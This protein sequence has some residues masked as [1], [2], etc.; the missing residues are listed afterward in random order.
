[1]NGELTRN[2]HT[3]RSQVSELGWLFVQL[4]GGE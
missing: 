3:L 2:G 4:A 1:L